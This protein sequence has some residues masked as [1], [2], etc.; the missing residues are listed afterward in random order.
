M[1]LSLSSTSNTNNKLILYDCGE[2]SKAWTSSS[3]PSL[4][5]HY[6]HLLHFTLS[7]NVI[8]YT[9]SFQHPKLH[10]LLVSYVQPIGWVENVCGNASYEKHKYRWDFI[11]LWLKYLLKYLSCNVCIMKCRYVSIK[12]LLKYFIEILS[13]LIEMLVILI[14]LNEHKVFMEMHELWCILLMIWES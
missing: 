14:Y 13:Y 2:W 12:S 8:L 10:H 3:F 7:N 4:D 5:R 11:C 9:A 1:S 6:H